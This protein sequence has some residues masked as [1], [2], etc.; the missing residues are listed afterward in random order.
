MDFI[1]EIRERAKT[2][3]K[4]IV[5]PEGTDERVLKAAE[6]IKKVTAKVALGN[7]ENLKTWQ[8]INLSGIDIIDPELSPK[9]E[10][11]ANHYMS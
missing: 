10:E 9:L 6:I 7:Q 8:D 4:T 1:K 5:L 2:S 11:Y 3:L